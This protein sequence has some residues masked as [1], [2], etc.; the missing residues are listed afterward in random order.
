VPELTA[1]PSVSVIVPVYKGERFLAEAL[2]SVAAQT[3]APLETIVVDDGS[4]DRSAEIAAGRAGVQ[5]V[6]QANQG[7]AAARNAGLAVARGE[8][9]AFLDQDDQWLPQKLALQV[10]HLRTHADVAVVLT[11][12]EHG[13]GP[14]AP[15][16]PPVVSAAPGSSE[17][18]PGY[19]PSVWLGAPRGVRARSGSSTPP[20]EIACDSDWLARAKDAGLRHRD[21]PRRAR[22]LAGARRER[23]RIEQDAMR[24]ELLRMTRATAARQRAAAAG[25]EPGT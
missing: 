2:E 7:V 18:Q 14:T 9:V 19:T 15:P 24:A 5:V 22:P 25:R 1:Q 8:L 11:H 12:M 16:R 3:Y 10:D 4:P 23:Q 6:R 21:A 20:T 13:P 17:P